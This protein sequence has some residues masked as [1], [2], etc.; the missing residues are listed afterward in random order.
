MTPD[1][2]S[3]VFKMFEQIVLRFEITAI[4]ERTA[5][6]KSRPFECALRE[7][8]GALD[9]HL[10]YKALADVLRYLEIQPLV[11][12]FLAAKREMDTARQVCP[13]VSDY[14]LLV[15]VAAYN[16]ALAALLE[17]RPAPPKE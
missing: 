8:F 10:I 6:V 11:D 13:R 7:H 2:Q 5:S 17:A 4:D 14:R 9:H 12:A 16:S 15:A 3:T 1:Y